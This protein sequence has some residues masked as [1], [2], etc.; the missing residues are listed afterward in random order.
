MSA[1]RRR[2]WGSGRSKVN[3]EI[4]PHQNGEW[5]KARNE[6]EKKKIRTTTRKDQ[7]AAETKKTRTGRA[8][9]TPLK[10]HRQKRHAEDD[11]DENEER[12]SKS[13]NETKTTQR[14]ER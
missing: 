6:G 11:A 5:K 4:R 2:R 13:F 12:R 7:G 14:R 9:T 8:A 1:P 3:R 10:T